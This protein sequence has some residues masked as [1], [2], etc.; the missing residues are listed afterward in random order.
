M[1]NYFPEGTLW[2]HHLVA[3]NNNTNV[4][5]VRVMV[6]IECISVHAIKFT[7]LNIKHETD[8]SLQQIETLAVARIIC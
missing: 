8:T 4:G 2:V 1:H 7:A 6:C 3:I 5:V